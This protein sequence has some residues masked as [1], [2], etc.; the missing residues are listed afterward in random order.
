MLGRC[1]PPIIG[2]ATHGSMVILTA[3]N[4]ASDV[5]VMTLPIGML[6]G[7]RASWTTKVGLGAIFALAWFDIGID[8]ARASRSQGAMESGV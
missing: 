6:L 8:I 4:I 2:L 1:N 7:L 3:L 5:A